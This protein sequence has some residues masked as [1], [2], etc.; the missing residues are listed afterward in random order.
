MGLKK[1]KNKIKNGVKDVAN[2]IAD[3]TVDTSTMIGS[4]IVKFAT[5][6]FEELDFVSKIKN[7]FKKIL[8]LFSTVIEGMDESSKVFTGLGNKIQQ[9]FK[10]MSG[11]DDVLLSIL[12]TAFSGF[13]TFLMEFI[14]LMGKIGNFILKKLKILEIIS[15]ISS[16]LFII[17]SFSI[18]SLFFFIFSTFLSRGK[19]ALFA[20]ATIPL[21]L[22]LFYFLVQDVSK[23]FNT[24]IDLITKDNVLTKEI[25]KIINDMADEINSIFK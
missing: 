18:A 11:L 20:L 22:V 25:E 8:S 21:S 9:F 10:F 6:T 12:N 13:N 5:G 17:Y 2:D 19:A 7:I 16:F 14:K 24:V 3:F 15:Y 1:I 4:S 23:K